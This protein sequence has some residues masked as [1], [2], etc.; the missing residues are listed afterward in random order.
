MLCSSGLRAGKKRRAIDNEPVSVG[1]GTDER[2]KSRAKLAWA[3][4]CKEE[5]DDSQGSVARKRHCA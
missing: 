4:P 5:E 2:S 1:S 3:M